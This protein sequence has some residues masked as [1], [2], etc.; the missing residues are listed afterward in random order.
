MLL[1]GGRWGK[2][3]RRSRSA[4]LGVVTVWDVPP[5]SL[6]RRL[7]LRWLLRGALFRIRGLKCGE[8]LLHLPRDIQEEVCYE[9]KLFLNL[10]KL[11]ALD[12][13]CQVVT[14]VIDLC[15]QFQ[16]IIGHGNNRQHF[17]A[18]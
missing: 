6:G 3:E 9:A 7:L 8:D 10:D 17:L 12:R 2:R 16:C 1:K 11:A 4:V 15:R 14:T 18:P 5:G 13:Q